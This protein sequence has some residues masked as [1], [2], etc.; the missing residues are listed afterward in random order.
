[1]LHAQGPRFTFPS[2]HNAAPNTNIVMPLRAFNLDSVVAMQ[3]VVRWDPLVLRF[4]TVDMFN[5]G[6]LAGGDFNTTHALDSGFVRLQWEGPTSIPPGTSVPDSTAIFRMR[7]K[8]IG[9]CTDSSPVTITE[10]LDFPPLNFEVVK[11]LQ[12]TSNVAYNLSQCPH[13]NGYA[14]VCYS[15][16]THEPT[17]EEIPLTLAPNPFLVDAE[18]NF[19]LTETSDIQLVI[20]DMQG[21]QVYEKKLFQVLPGQHGMVIEKEMLGTPG[22]YSLTLRAGRKTATRTLAL[23]KN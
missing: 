20:T 8:V 5:L 4:F 12:D 13:T 10:I 19:N 6:D 22:L 15:V 7:F 2:I 3:M 17:P 23:L 9:A 21:R 16:P 1:M 18:L 11:V 14:I